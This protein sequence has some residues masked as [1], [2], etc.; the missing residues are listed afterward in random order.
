MNVSAHT[1]ML[2]LDQESVVRAIN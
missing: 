1:A 2:N